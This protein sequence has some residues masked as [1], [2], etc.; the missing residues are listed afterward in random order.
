MIV[1]NRAG[2]GGNIGAEYVARADADGQTL[3]FG[4]SGPLAI[5][6]SLYRKI[7][8][9]PVQQLRAGDPGRAPAERA[10]GEPVACPR[11]T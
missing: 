7:N 9:D 2:A 8:Y 6:S 11:R 10:G 3:L 4:T 1:E 5:N